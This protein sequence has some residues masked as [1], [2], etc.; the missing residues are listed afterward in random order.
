[1]ANVEKKLEERKYK[2]KRIQN[3]MIVSQASF[4]SQLCITLDVS[5]SKFNCK[6]VD[7][8]A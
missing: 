8:S 3:G 4:P 1:M 2:K 7:K 5:F 6:Y